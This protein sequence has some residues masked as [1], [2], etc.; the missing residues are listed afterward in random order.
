MLPLCGREF[1]TRG[2][3]TQYTC[4][5]SHLGHTGDRCFVYAI[6]S[7]RSCA[8][9]MLYYDGC[10][11]LNDFPGMV[12]ARQVAFTSWHLFWWTWPPVCCDGIVQRRW[13]VGHMCRSVTLWIEYCSHSLLWFFGIKTPTWLR[14][15]GLWLIV[16]GMDA[17]NH[18][19]IDIILKLCTTCVSYNS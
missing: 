12:S 16:H 10:Y 9:E 5:E 17:Y 19:E 2:I 7:N 8:V 13:T 11:T 6:E 14:Y 1:T 4:M 3:V 18:M 15:G